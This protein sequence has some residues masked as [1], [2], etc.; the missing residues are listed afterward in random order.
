[1]NTQRQRARRKTR[2]QVQ[3]TSLLREVARCSDAPLAEHAREMLAAIGARVTQPQAKVRVAAAEASDA[4]G[5][6]APS[7]VCRAGASCAET[8]LP[9]PVS[10]AREERL[11]GPT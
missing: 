5:V 1:M 4:R 3:A 10:N 11:H 6:S 8:A 7:R 2:A 9:E